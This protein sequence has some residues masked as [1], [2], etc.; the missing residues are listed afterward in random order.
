M[1]DELA[2]R[3]HDTAVA[4]GFWETERNMGEMLALISSEISEA[5]EAHRDARPMW[6]EPSGKPEG[7]AVELADAIIR[8]LDILFHLHGPEIDAL[9]DI[10]TGGVV[11]PGPDVNFGE[12]LMMVHERVARAFNNRIN[13]RVVVM[14]LTHVVILCEAYIEDCGADP[15]TTIRLKMDYND[16]RPYKHGKAY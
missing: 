5:L 16:T 12:R 15:E 4:K 2:K 10:W 8:C 3:A 14:F 13:Q 7:Q 9:V 6:V 1:Y 11:V